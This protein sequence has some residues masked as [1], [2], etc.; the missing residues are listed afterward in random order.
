MRKPVMFIAS[1]AAV[2]LAGAALFGFALRE[3]PLPR[4]ELLEALLAEADDDRL[5]EVFARFI[6]TEAGF[7]DQ[8][9]V[10][11]ANGFRCATIPAS[12]EGSQY[13]S[14]DRPI[15]GTGYCEGVRYYAYQTAAGDITDVLG[16]SY[17]ARRNQN[18]LG[19]CEEARQHFFTLS[20]TSV[21]LAPL[22]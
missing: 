12:V 8:A 13:L 22:P 19:R 9:P 17:N 6:P 7:A 21:E 5:T 3:E 10:L 1:L 15:E 14:C 4:G 2:A 20:D 16:S 18:V 11:F